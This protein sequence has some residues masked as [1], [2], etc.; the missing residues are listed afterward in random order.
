MKTKRVVTNVC[1]TVSA[2]VGVGFI[3]G[4]EAVTFVGNGFNAVVFGVVFSLFLA[5]ANGVIKTNANIDGLQMFCNCLP[6]GK[7]FYV[8]LLL[9][10]FACVISIFSAYESCLQLITNLH[11]PLP[12]FS[13]AIGFLCFFTTKYNLKILK[14]LSKFSTTA[15]MLFLMCCLTKNAP[16][17][18][19]QTQSVSTLS[20]VVYALFSATLCLGVVC[21]TKPTNAQNILSGGVLAI[22]TCIALYL[23]K[24]NGESAVPL[25]VRLS[26]LSGKVLTVCTVTLCT[27]TGVAST[28]IPLVTELTSVTDD[29][30][31]S[32]LTILLFALIFS[33]FG[34]E[35]VVKACYK[36]VAV[37]AVF[38]FIAMLYATKKCRSRLYV[39]PKSTQ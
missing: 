19:N 29:S 7:V 6:G 2:V 27:A 1:L 5:V 14:K 21:K 8:L 10:F 38:L 4:K 34:L 13:F 28:A 26:S 17:T 25:A 35:N 3:S 23:C 11:F 37:F 24:S 32:L 22:L 20:A 33:V 16:T 12:V 39:S 9:C 31:F 30:D 36:A 15:T 18:G